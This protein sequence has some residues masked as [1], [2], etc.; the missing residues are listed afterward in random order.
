[1]WKRCADGLEKRSALLLR[2]RL[3]GAH[4][5]QRDVHVARGSFVD[6]IACTG[7]VLDAADQAAE[8]SGAEV[9]A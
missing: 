3:R 9:G 1:M 8:V 2:Q 7:C 4:A 6:V 5:A